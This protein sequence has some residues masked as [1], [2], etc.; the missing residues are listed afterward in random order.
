M[1][2]IKYKLRKEHEDSQIITKSES[3]QEVLIHKDN[4]TDYWAEQMLANGQAHLIEIKPQF[5]PELVEKKSFVHVSENVIISTFG[6]EQTGEI[7]QK[8][9]ANEP[10]LK[11][12][13]GRPSKVKQ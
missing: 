8:P 9:T 2:A 5:K 12:K 11:R 10:E 6:K 7:E 3:G 4:F 13:P 1:E